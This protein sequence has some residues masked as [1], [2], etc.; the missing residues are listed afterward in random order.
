[1]EK[2]EPSC[3]VREIADWCSHC[4]NSMEFPQKIK[5]GTSLWHRNSTPGNVSKETQ[6]TDL[7]EYMHP[8]DHWVLFT[9]PQFGRIGILICRIPYSCPQ[10]SNSFLSFCSLTKGFW[11]L[12]HTV[13]REGTTHSKYI[14]NQLSALNILFLLFLFFHLLLLLL[15]CCYMVGSTAHILKC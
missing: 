6:N 2:R 12:Y 8:Y 4:K 15:K 5:D 7:K 14:G 3:P 13:D 1:M 10:I 9:I 11:F